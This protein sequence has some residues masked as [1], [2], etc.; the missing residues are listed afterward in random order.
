MEFCNFSEEELRLINRA[1]TF[2]GKKE[3][4]LDRVFGR[5]T[6]IKTENFADECRQLARYYPHLGLESAGARLV[7]NTVKDRD[8]QILLNSEGIDGL[9][10]VHALTTQ[11][12]HLGNLSRYNVDHGN[13]YRLSPEQAIADHYYE[14]LLWSTFLATKIATRVHAL[15]AWH[16]VNGEAPPADG[17][18]RFAQIAFPGQR[19]R[20]ALT[21]AQQSENMSAR[22]EGYWDLLVE[23]ARYF[24]CL[25]FYQQE[26]R[27]TE[28]DG[29]F[30]VELIREVVGLDNCLAFYGTLLRARDYPAWQ[31]EKRTLRRFIVAMQDQGKGKFLTE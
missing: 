13:V 31:A 25:A 17:R 24:G 20:A 7:F 9:S 1:L 14:F 19:I 28:L 5:T 10:C 27:P 18:Y 22:Q 6:V 8:H 3:V 16:Q 21:A 2:I 15:V 4:G 11:L 26:P 29:R 30:P 12:V 23:L